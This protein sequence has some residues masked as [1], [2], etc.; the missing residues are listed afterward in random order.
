MFGQ[1]CVFLKRNGFEG[2]FFEGDIR[3]LLKIVVELF[4]SFLFDRISFESLFIKLKRLYIFLQRLHD[5]LHVYTY[6]GLYF[7]S[8]HSNYQQSTAIFYLKNKTVLLLFL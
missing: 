5:S 7:Q 4:E 8:N 6:F 3:V 1:E 2:F